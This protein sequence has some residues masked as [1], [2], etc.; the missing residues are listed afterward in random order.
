M[1]RFDCEFCGMTSSHLTRKP[2]QESS[3]FARDL[4]SAKFGEA[5]HEL[6]PGQDCQA[7]PLLKNRDKYAVAVDRERG[8]CPI[9]GIP[10]KPTRS[11]EDVA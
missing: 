3:P 11:S 8:D 7:G 6:V 5:R 1:A 2:A 10:A 9:F 4:G